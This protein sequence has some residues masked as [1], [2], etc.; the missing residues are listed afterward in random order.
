[1]TQ[2]EYQEKG[3]CLRDGETWCDNAI[4]CKVCFHHTPNAFFFPLLPIFEL[5]QLQDVKQ[6][7]LCPL[8]GKVKFYSVVLGKLC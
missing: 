2:Q 7:S 3:V 4:N 1:M 5:I 8:T 6:S